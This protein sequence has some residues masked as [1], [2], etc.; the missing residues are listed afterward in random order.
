MTAWGR[1]VVHCRDRRGGPGRRGH[2]GGGR[3][4]TDE[5]GAGARHLP[6][7]SARLA[8]DADDLR[9]LRFGITLR[10]YAM[11]Q[12]DDV[13]DR[14]GREIAERDA[15]IAALRAGTDGHPDGPWP[16]L[17]PS[18]TPKVSVRL[19]VATEV[20]APVTRVGTSWST[21]PASRAGSPSPRCASRRTTRPAW[22]C[23]RPRCP[24]SG[25]AGCP[26]GCSTGSWSPD[27]R[28]PRRPTT[29]SFPLPRGATPPN[30]PGNA[31]D[32]PSSRCSTWPYFTGVGVFAL[33]GHPAGTRVSAVELFDLPGGRLLEPPGRLLL[34]VLRQGFR[35]SLRR[36]AAVCES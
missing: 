24:A 31:P 22:A 28:H 15:E 36:F 29:A 23:G 18:T 12:V 3:S 33:H 19:E 16:P 6:A 5:R 13:L 7:G 35:L 2:G 8:A 11:A 14:L 20:R 10:G 17:R 1:G 30:P 25:S 21:G 26:S 4:G 9:T 34:P 32:G 27:G